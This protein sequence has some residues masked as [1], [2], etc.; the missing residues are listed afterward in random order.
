MSKKR[1]T[2]EVVSTKMDKTIVISVDTLKTHRVYKK[3][4][5]GA[6]KYK[7][8]DEIGVKLGERVVIEECIPFSKTVTWK[9][10]TKL[11]EGK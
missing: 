9:V 2:G 7:A 5:R 6:K 10:I 3:L 4:I 1:L 8:R 11:E